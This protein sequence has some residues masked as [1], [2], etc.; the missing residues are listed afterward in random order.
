ML[1]RLALHPTFKSKSMHITLQ[2]DIQRVTARPLT[3]RVHASMA[4]L[5]LSYLLP[6]MQLRGRSVPAPSLAQYLSFL[7]CLLP[8]QSP[9]S[10]LPWQLKS[11]WVRCLFRICFSRNLI[12][13]KR[14]AKARADH[15]INR[16]QMMVTWAESCRHAAKAEHGALR[17]LSHCHHLMTGKHWSSAATRAQLQSRRNFRCHCSVLPP[18][19]KECLRLSFAEDHVGHP[20]A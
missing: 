18:V 19:L 8:M 15:A 4:D 16:R 13:R 7:L 3:S 20:G 14:C 10:Q 5:R 6:M 1:Y 9:V 2:R 17:V 11:M 12:N